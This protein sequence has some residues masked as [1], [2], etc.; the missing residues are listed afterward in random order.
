MAEIRLPI[1]ADLNIDGQAVI[2]LGNQDLTTG[3]A[4]HA[5]RRDYVDASAVPTSTVGGAAIPPLERVGGSGD[6]SND[7]T[8]EVDANYLRILNPNYDPAETDMTAAASQQYL[9][10][11]VAGSVEALSDTLISAAAT[12]NFLRY[13][14]TNWVNTDISGDDMAAV[15]IGDLD[16]VADSIGTAGQLLQVNSDAD[17][18]IYVSLA[19]AVASTTSGVALENLNNVPALPAETAT[20]DQ[21][22]SV[23]VWD[24]AGNSFSWV[25][26]TMDHTYLDSNGRFSSVEF[27]HL[28]NVTTA[29][30][31]SLADTS[32]MVLSKDSSGDVT[33][34]NPRIVVQEENLGNRQHS[35]SHIRFVGQGVEVTE[36]SGV[37]IVTITGG[38]G[39]DA[40]T[41]ADY[42]FAPAGGTAET[43]VLDAT[44]AI[45]TWSYVITAPDG[46]YFP[47][48]DNTAFVV[49]DDDVS[50]LEVTASM[51]SA[52]TVAGATYNWTAATYSA[53]QS[54]EQA[55]G[56]SGTTRVVTGFTVSFNS[57]E[58]FV[59]E[60]ASNFTL[61]A[62]LKPIS[63]AI[64]DESDQM[65]SRA[66]T[67]A[68]N[69]YQQFFYA[70]ASQDYSTYVQ[71]GS[72]ATAETSPGSG[73][74]LFAGVTTYGEELES[75][76][77]FNVSPTTAGTTEYL[78]LWIPN[79]FAATAEVILYAGGFQITTEPQDVIAGIGA[80][81][82]N[83]P[84]D[85]ADDSIG[86]AGDAGVKI[87]YTL[88]K[89]PFRYRTSIE[90]RN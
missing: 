47:K 70:R 7:L 68:P 84:W 69:I 30:Q 55:V 73:V 11:P 60:A 36:D 77:V 21:A 48:T 86:D 19:S 64:D 10:V 35:V 38:G 33:L 12:G 81:L 51:P 54:S 87:G 17:G 39:G 43:Q 53:I 42:T 52:S 44:D 15:S 25:S 49:A 9:Y 5:A 66:L 76:Y 6:D 18:H 61:Q 89:I 45:N 22:H 62:N 90:I 78:S 29:A 79:S 40:A 26:S 2:D 56:G 50:D 34:K 57:P 88:F 28:S 75:G 3:G 67:F 71:T 37:G 58:G 72:I 1:V 16:D 82:N 27:N 32:N 46:Y 83:A 14:G 8:G 74:N 80:Q 24:D 13:N 63:D 31:G 41:R 4:D 59:G 65:T 20:A 85:T 23:L